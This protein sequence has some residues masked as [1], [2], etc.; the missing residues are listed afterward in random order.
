MKS[1]VPEVVL[2]SASSRRREL[3]LPFFP[4]LIVVPSEVE[5]GAMGDESPDNLVERLASAKAR[6]VA[7]DYVDAL[8]IGAD[9]VVVLEGDVLGKPF[10]K[11]EVLMMLERLS[12]KWHRVITGLALVWNGREEVSCALTG[13]RFAHLSREEMEF[14]AQTGEP[15][16]KAGAYGIQGMGAFFVEEIEG[17]YSNVVGLPLRLLYV[18][19]SRLGLDLKQWMGK[20]GERL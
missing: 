1:L 6:A 18:L 5:E 9:T 13:V 3:L 11:D 19:M 15:M 4:R 10:S 14:Y 8:V 12:G 2:A 17:S 7:R 16:D 20:R